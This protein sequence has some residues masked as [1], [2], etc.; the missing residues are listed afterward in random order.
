MIKV[1]VGIQVRLSSTRLTRKALYR[2]DDK[3]L[4]FH[5]LDRVHQGLYQ[6]SPAAIDYDVYLLTPFDE[7]EF[8]EEMAKRYNDANNTKV[9]NLSGSMDNVFLRYN[10]MFNQKS[11][12]YIVRITGDC[13]FLPP[14]QITTI[15]LTSF[16]SGC[17]YLSN[18][19]PRYRTEP[20]GYDCEV[21]GRRAFQWLADNIENGNFSH[22]EHVT[23]Y[24]REKHPEHFKVGCM[25]GNMDL[26]HLKCSIDTAEDYDRMKYK[27]DGLLRR[28]KAAKER[29]YQVYEY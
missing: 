21:I 28:I 29:G 20:D 10:A 1:A 23:T 17:D 27:H 24:F 9:I 12:E 26:S 4:L 8:W 5:T 16:A 22:K 13:P 7:E 15:L 6:I 25:V 14:N 18:V 3:V 2:I 11:Y 19:D